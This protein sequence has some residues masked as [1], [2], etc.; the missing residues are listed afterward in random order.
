MLPRVTIVV[1]VLN[2]AAAVPAL[3]WRL[4]ALAAHQVVIV[5]GGSSDGTQERLRAGGLCVIDGPRGRALQMNVGAQHTDGDVL[6]YLHAD[7]A[8]S[9]M[10]LR[11]LQ[12]AVQ[13][14]CDFGCF[15]VTFDT[16]DPRLLLVAGLISLRSRCIVSATG[17]QA[18]FMRRSLL[19]ELGGYRPLALCEDLDLIRRA[20]G[21]GRFRCL[22]TAVQTSARRWKNNGVLRTIVLMW[23][24]R[25]GCHIGLD[26]QLLKQL[27]ED[28]R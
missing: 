21:H 1:P 20:R 22:D 5:D 3:T 16:L 25:L 23:S 17:D 10:Q 9:P 27:Y 13:D 28:A 7:T 12:S 2:E 6:L 19:N 11:Q 26:P 24:L 14:G 4:R 8:I 15:G 18:I